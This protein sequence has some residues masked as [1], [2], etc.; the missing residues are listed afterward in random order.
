MGVVVSILGPFVA[1]AGVWL[2]GWRTARSTRHAANQDQRRRALADLRQV[3]SSY[4]TACRR[5]ADHVKHPANKV[6]VVRSTDASLAVPLLNAEGAALRQAI[7]VAAADLL[8]TAQSSAAVEQARLL[9]S[10]SI[11]LAIARAH[12]DSGIIPASD[13]HAFRTAEQAYVDAARLDLGM[14]MMDVAMWGGPHD[15]PHPPDGDEQGA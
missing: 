6:E 9:R 5:F 4:L 10:K 7:E 15:L 3:Y 8:L 1:L 13:I 14:P 2:G 12:S 11:S